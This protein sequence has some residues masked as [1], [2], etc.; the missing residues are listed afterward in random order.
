MQ[1][2]LLHKQLMDPYSRGRSSSS[3]PTCVSDLSACASTNHGRDC[4]VNT[5]KVTRYLCLIVVQ[6]SINA[7]NTK[8]VTFESGIASLLIQWKGL[9][10]DVLIENSLQ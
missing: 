6:S 5:S 8:D 4:R 10:G 1:L 2:L 9:N 7:S 3:A